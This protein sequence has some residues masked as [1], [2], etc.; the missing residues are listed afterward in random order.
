VEQN[1]SKIFGLKF[2]LNEN[3]AKVVVKIVTFA[4]WMLQTLRCWL[5]QL[6]KLRKRL[7]Q[8]LLNATKI[9]MNAAAIIIIFATFATFSFLWKQSWN[10]WLGTVKKVINFD[11]W[12]NAWTLIF[13]KCLI[14]WY[15]K[16]KFHSKSKKIVL[17]SYSWKSCGNFQSYTS[18]IFLCPLTCVTKCL[19]ILDNYSLWWMNATLIY[20]YSFKLCFSW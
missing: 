2:L 19:T 15:E 9:V 1:L 4:S 8:F 6:K 5:R 18:A 16:M 13:T 3:N 14:F 12:S 20:F 10:L 7:P 17:I 11:F